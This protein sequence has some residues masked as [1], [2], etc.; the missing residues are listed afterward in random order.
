MH[1]TER[2]RRPDLGHLS[3]ELII[4]DEKALTRPYKF[5]RSFTLAPGW[6]L[7][8][9]YLSGDSGR[10]QQGSRAEPFSPI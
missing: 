1:L 10:D 6:E 2:Y 4:E 5:T 3:V 9:I 8:R 7:Q